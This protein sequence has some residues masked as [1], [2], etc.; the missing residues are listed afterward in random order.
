MEG[1]TFGWTMM[2]I[3]MGGT[4]ITLYLLILIIQ[5]M[6]KLFPAVNKAKQAGKEPEKP[7]GKTA[8]QAY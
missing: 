6:M 4:L 7:A 3:G 1:L 5:L 8:G 2:V